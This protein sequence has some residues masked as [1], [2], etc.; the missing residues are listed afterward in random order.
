[1]NKEKLLKEANRLLKAV[2]RYTGKKLSP[3]TEEELKAVQTIQKEWA[4]AAQKQNAQEHSYTDV[5]AGRE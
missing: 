5:S 3:I 1:M 4:K 2:E